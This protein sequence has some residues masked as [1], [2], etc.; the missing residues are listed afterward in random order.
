M[1]SILFTGL[2]ILP[3]LGPAQESEGDVL[4]LRQ[5]NEDQEVLTVP[6]LKTAVR[7]RIDFGLEA[8]AAFTTFGR[9]GS[10]FSSYLAPE[11]R[12]Q[13][14]PRVHFSAGVIFSTGFIPGAGL[15]GIGLAGIGQ[16]GTAGSHFNRFL[17]FAEGTYRVNQRLSIGGMV[18]KELD[19]NLYRQINAFQRNS[20]FQSMGMSV[21]YKITD[22]INIGARINVTE[23]RPYYYT[24]PTNPFIRRSIFSPGW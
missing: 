13:A 20:G 17:V 11:I 9:H 10:M 8:G 24:D 23:G 18:V 4:L 12:Y 21:N 1:R 15:D 6:E 7:D 14:T 19:N 3:L 5:L 16:G 22:N 2:L